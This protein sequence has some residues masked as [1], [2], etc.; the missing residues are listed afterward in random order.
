[1]DI[2]ML[3]GVGNDRNSKAVAGYIECSETNAVHADRSLL[4]HQV[5]ECGRELDGVFETSIIFG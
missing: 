1:M 4:D 5:G 3:K 2:R